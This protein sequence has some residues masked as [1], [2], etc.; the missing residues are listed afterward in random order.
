MFT[1]HALHITIDS[2]KIINN[3]S[4]QVESSSIHT[5]MGPNGSG[6]SSLAYAIAGHPLYAIVQGTIMFNGQLLN[7]L[8][9]D[10]RARLGI[11]LTFQHPPALPGVRV[12]TF[13]KEAYTAMTGHTCSVKEF[14]SLL[15][16]YLELLAID[17]LFLHRNLHE[18][19]SGGEKK[20]FEILQ[21]LVLKPKLAILDEVDSGLDIDAL[22]LVAQA[23][24]FARQENPKISIMLITHY[25]RILHYIQ[26]DQ[27]H[28]LCDGTIVASGNAQLVHTLEQQGYD[29]Y[30]T[31]SQ[32][33]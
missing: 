33:I 13:L 12:L 21:L 5:L 30:R 20:K 26:P 32:A 29:G 23:L 6:K 31:S 1:I 17:P 28:I 19:F 8:S 3:L 2:K 14:S 9:C 11:F 22:K 25:Q 16:P 18:G 27:V 7:D 10:V 15:T 4:L 24:L